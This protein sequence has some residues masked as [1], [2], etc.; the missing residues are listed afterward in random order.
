VRKLIVNKSR[1][2]K[3]VRLDSHVLGRLVNKGT[4]QTGH[5]SVP[6]PKLENTRI[7]GKMLGDQ[8]LLFTL[9]F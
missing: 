7:L 5:G 4:H 3:D 1:E 8:K 2:N 9:V 6:G